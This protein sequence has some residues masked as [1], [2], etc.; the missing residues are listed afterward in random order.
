M[1]NQVRFLSSFFGIDLGYYSFPN[2]SEHRFNFNK[3]SPRQVTSFG[4]KYDTNSIMHYD[5]YA[6]SKDPKRYI[7]MKPKIP[8]EYMGYAKVLS[9]VN[10]TFS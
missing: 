4:V 6:F 8:N 7:V 9:K 2:I 3:L 10:F 5:K 1:L